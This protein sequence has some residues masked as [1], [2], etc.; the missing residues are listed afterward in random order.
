VS[1]YDLPGNGDEFEPDAEP[2]VLGN[3]R[4]IKTHAEIDLFEAI[5]FSLAMEGSW[6]WIDDNTRLTSALICQ[7]H[8]DW[9]GR[10]Y[11]CAGHYRTVNLA[12][13]GYAAWCPAI[14][15]ESQMQEFEA[16]E[17]AKTTPCRGTF[18]E[19][20]DAIALV[21]ERFLGIHPFREGN[22]RLSRWIADLMAMQVG[23]SPLNWEMHSKN[24]A[25]KELYYA[26]VQSA[27]AGKMEALTAL[28]RTSLEL[29][30]STP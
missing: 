24:E 16:E 25:G 20:V 13:G 2:G 26:A 17:L 27:H 22:G 19:V 11:P 15:I 29:G 23:L 4:G 21:H 3:L 30:Q 18:D 6:E 14:Y 7:L 28:I 9:L 10:L 12:K 1:R 5:L 8:E